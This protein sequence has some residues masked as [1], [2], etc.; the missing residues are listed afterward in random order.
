M[1]VSDGW[2]RWRRRRG[3]SGSG[4]VWVEDE[5]RWEFAVLGGEREEKRD[6]QA[7]E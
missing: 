6:D 1:D 2:Q 4:G 7:E 3:G 5:E